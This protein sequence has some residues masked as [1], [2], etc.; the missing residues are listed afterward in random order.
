MVTF[1][2]LSCLYK[3]RDACFK[4]ITLNSP[5]VETS[6]FPGRG[7]QLCRRNRN[8]TPLSPDPALTRCAFSRC[9]LPGFVILLRTHRSIAAGPLLAFGGRVTLCFLPVLPLC[10][11]GKSYVRSGVSV[12]T[13]DLSRLF[14]RDSI[15][16]LRW[17]HWVVWRRSDWNG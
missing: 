1:H 2:H 15:G 9:N 16:L 10:A 13:I 17:R 4:M 7:S 6:L 3:R 12:R 8:L 11:P 5:A 14:A